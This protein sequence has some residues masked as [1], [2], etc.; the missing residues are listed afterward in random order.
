MV[1]TSTED[2]LLILRKSIQSKD[3][4][5]INI[6]SRQRVL[7]SIPKMPTCYLYGSLQDGNY[8]EKKLSIVPEKSKD[9]HVLSANCNHITSKEKKWWYPTT[10]NAKT[11]AIEETSEE[12]EEIGDI[13][14][15]LA[16]WCKNYT[17]QKML[18]KYL[19]TGLLVTSKTQKLDDVKDDIVSIDD[20]NDDS[21]DDND[22]NDDDSDT[23]DD[24]VDI[25]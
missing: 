12:T 3:T 19:G 6:S 24:G 20:V 25:E 2:V 4:T 16:M 9:I 13:C 1:L 22:D 10:I 17:E 15:R 23:D 11:E 14:K 5:I 7:P 18:L 21:G 8:V